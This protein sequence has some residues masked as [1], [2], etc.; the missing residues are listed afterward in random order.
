ML[1]LETARDICRAPGDS[2]PG[3]I[4]QAAK[5]VEAELA[6][7]DDIPA[8][9]KLAVEY[10]TRVANIEAAHLIREAL[11]TGKT[12]AHIADELEKR[13]GAQNSTP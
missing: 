9:V 1:T 12:I 3:A 10:G 4:A 2:P 7:Y 6:Q 8:A 11:T 5:M 13:G